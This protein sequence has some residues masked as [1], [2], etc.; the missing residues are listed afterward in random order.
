MQIPAFFF[1]F[2][3]MSFSN[4]FSLCAEEDY[5]LSNFYK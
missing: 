2:D 5:I 3:K 4:K 1:F